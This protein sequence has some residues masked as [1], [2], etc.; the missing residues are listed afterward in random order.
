MKIYNSIDEFAAAGVKNSLVTTG[1]FDGVHLG[2]KAI[3]K[4]ISELCKS[5]GHESVLLTFNPHPRTVL[6]P[7]GPPM[8]FLSTFAEK[9]ALLKEAGIQHL[10][11]HPFT[12]ELSRVSAL[13]Y[14]RNI[15]TG[16]LHAK[17]LV[18]GHDHRFGRNREGSI[19]ELKEWA[20]MYG[21]EVEEIAPFK[22]AEVTISSSKIRKA[23]AEGDL[24]TANAYLGY[25]YSLEAKVVHG[26]KLGSTKLGYPTANLEVLDKS[27]IIPADGIYAVYVKY[28]GQQYKGMMSIGLNPTV[29]GKGRSMEVNIFNFSEDI[30]GKNLYVSFYKKLRNEEKFDSLEAL[31]KQLDKDKEDSLKILA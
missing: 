31:K 21:F 16:K 26:L 13:D 11:I 30:Y 28:N 4:R 15:L 29:E 18:I 7:D 5:K 19:K 14:V 20:P 22:S 17:T 9:E 1:T 10:I 8:Q 24:Q 2:H 6:F 25:T 23:I 12:K 27:K 3:L